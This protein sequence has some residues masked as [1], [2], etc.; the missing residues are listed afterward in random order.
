MR[1]AYYCTLLIF[2]L[3]SSWSA[4]A[5]HIVG[6]EVTY[7]CVGN[8]NYRIE[9]DIYQ[10][11]LN[12]APQVIAEDNPAFIGIFTGTGTLLGHDSISL[13]SAI[14]VPPNFSNSCINN[15]PSTC[16]RKAA[17]IKTYNFPPSPSGYYIVY[18]RCCRNE[19]ITN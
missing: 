11:C 7:Q 16:L 14:L 1:R 9:I 18:Q 10:D 3:L 4:K 8:N 13:T 5:T 2:A 17:F 12:G 19:Q 6:G 15:P